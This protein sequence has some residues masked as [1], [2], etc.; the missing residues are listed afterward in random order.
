MVASGAHVAAERATACG[1]DRSS[2]P[3][4][5]MYAGG[6]VCADASA[7]GPAVASAVSSTAAA[8]AVSA[9][10]ISAAGATAVATSTLPSAATKAADASAAVSSGLAGLA[11]CA[12]VAAERAAL[13]ARG[14]LVWRL[15]RAMA[16]GGL[17]VWWLPDERG[18][19]GDWR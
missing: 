14:A 12:P 6:L 13:P 7:V 18:P 5:R 11:G 8:A 9:T 4:P 17:V 19:S 1:T 2:V 10:A 3:R 16:R 15:E